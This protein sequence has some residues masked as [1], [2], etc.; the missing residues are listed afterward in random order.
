MVGKLALVWRERA[1][2]LRDWG[3]D[4]GVAQLWERAAVELEQALVQAG[5]QVL[6]VKAAAEATGLSARHLR[7]M[8]TTGKLPNVGQRY[9]PRVRR[10]DLPVGK[11]LHVAPPEDSTKSP[12]IRDIANKLR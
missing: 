3:A 7:Q 12:R 10:A 5:Q 8:I 11:R 6:T 1:A 4:P 2:S 9:R